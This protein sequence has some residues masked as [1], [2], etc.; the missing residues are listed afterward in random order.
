[1]KNL[2]TIILISGCVLLIITISIYLYL[3]NSDAPPAGKFV[4]KWG[5]IFSTINHFSEIRSIDTS[6]RPDLIVV[7]SFED[8]SWFAGVCNGYVEHGWSASVYT[9]SSKR[10]FKSFELISGFE[11]LHHMIHNV[12]ARNLDV[13]ISKF[14]INLQEIQKKSI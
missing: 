6:N 1:M 4:K 12:D 8:G 5:G 9:D 10:I 2:K 13:F 11:A 3:Y 14:P 7:R